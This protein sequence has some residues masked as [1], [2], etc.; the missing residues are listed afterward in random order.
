M[1]VFK[2]FEQGY[3]ESGVQVIDD[4]GYN[5]LQLY[6]KYAWPPKF[7][8][9]T[10]LIF[11]GVDINDC[12]YDDNN[13]AAL[14]TA[15]KNAST[16]FCVFALLIELGANMD[17]YDRDLMTPVLI[18]SKRNAQPDVLNLLLENSDLQGDLTLAVLVPSLPVVVYKTV[19]EHGGWVYLNEIV[20]DDPPISLVDN[21]FVHERPH[22]E[23]QA[24]IR[25]FISMDFNLTLVSPATLK[26]IDR[27]TVVGAQIDKMNSLL[28]V[29]SAVNR[30]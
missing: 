9:C 19:L 14:M 16:P 6:L 12:E 3:T 17:V 10:S 18:V 2:Q 29:Y 25:Y 20:E 23:N 15:C 1:P 4:E 7:E 5:I 21:L 24:I 30:R 13:E 27:D 11:E 22:A 8:V 28:K 26:Q